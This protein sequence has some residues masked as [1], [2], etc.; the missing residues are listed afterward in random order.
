[1]TS[2][3]STQKQ[4][5]STTKY[6]FGAID[7]YIFTALQRIDK[8]GNIC[9]SRQRDILVLGQPLLKS[10]L[11]ARLTSFIEEG[12]LKIV[13]VD[14]TD[15]RLIKLDGDTREVLMVTKLFDNGIEAPAEITHDGKQFL[16]VSNPVN[17]ERYT[18]NF[19]L[20]ECKMIL[21]HDKGL[22]GKLSCLKYDAPNERLL[23][24]Y[25]YSHKCYRYFP[26]CA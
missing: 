17:K 23:V 3:T 24:S 25:G 9:W 15:K 7:F 14:V 16:Y 1:M 11:H 20:T 10:Q 2:V 18:W 4:R 21:S 6:V 26:F 19:E 12:K 22:R 5:F 13:A 8:Q